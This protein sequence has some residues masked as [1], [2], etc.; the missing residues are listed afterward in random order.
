[1]NKLLL[2][3]TVTLVP[4]AQAA[5]FL[6]TVN[7]SSINPLLGN[8]ALDYSTQNAQSSFAAITGFTGATL[9][10]ALPPLGTV[11][12]GLPTNNL[13][14]T[15]TNPGSNYAIGANFNNN[16][17]SFLLSLYGPAVDTPNS[18]A[19]GTTFS[20]QMYDATFS[21]GLLTQD[22]VV[23]LIEIDRKSVV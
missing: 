20:V 17:F 10:A 6:V 13:V 8:L 14:I 3:L 19:G 12:G 15:A 16:S 4:A 11:S 5:A 18:G 22:G 1:M 2:A 7:T 21:N 9:G 23:G